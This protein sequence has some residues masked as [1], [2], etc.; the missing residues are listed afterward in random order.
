M[1]KLLLFSLVAIFLGFYACKKDNNSPSNPNPGDTTKKDTIEQII[2]LK[3]SFGTMYMWLNKETPLHRANFIKLTDSGFFD[4]TTFHRIIPGFVIQGGDP[5]TKDADP[6]NDGNGGPGYTVPAEINSQ[7]KHDFGAI[8]AAR[9]P[10]NVNPQ[11]ESSGSQFYIVVGASGQHSLDGAYTV[12]GKVIS[13]MNVATTIMN[14]PRGA[15]DRPTTDIKMDVNVVNKT[16]AQLRTE[17]NF[18]P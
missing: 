4:S 3:T 7:F 11:R 1:K 14:Q 8:G 13:G 12:F 9:L 15:K 16:R 2:E 17:F 6:A 18:T 5:L 10:D